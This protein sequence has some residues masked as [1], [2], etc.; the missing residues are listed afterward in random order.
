MVKYLTVEQLIT[1]NAMQEGGVGVQSRSGVE[2]NAAR[3]Q[4]GFGG[5]E[6][7]PDL[8][9][10]AAAYA[11]GIASTQYFTDGNKRTAWFAAVTFLRLNGVPFPTV[12]D[13]EAEAFVYTVA[14]DVWKADDAPD[15][16]IEKAAEWF[17]S[18]YDSPESTPARFGPCI[19]PRLEYMFL[20]SWF[21]EHESQ[22]FSVKSG[23]LT[24]MAT[25]A[26]LPM[27]TNL[28]ILGAFHWR[29]EDAG[30]RHPTEVRIVPVEPQG[31]RRMVT[32]ATVNLMSDEP[33][34][35]AHPEHPSG[36]MPTMFKWWMNPV[37]HVAARYSVELRIDRELV[38]SI[39]F[40]F[41]HQ[42]PLPD[43]MIIERQ[44]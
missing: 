18:K 4:S 21:D 9:T 8:W 42:Q 16:S 33:Y 6:T 13:I 27:P 23:G 10:K 19:N 28:A 17:R 24:A 31:R 14:L 5:Y 44:V 22:T 25:T 38:G 32:R 3:P 1:I 12:S 30:R 37:F 26:A 2:Q 35:S 39:P 11:H 34:P 40:E 43:F 41:V 15:R 36:L 20:A 29:K 7:F